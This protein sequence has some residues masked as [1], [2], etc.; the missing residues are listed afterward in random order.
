MLAGLSAL[1]SILLQTKNKEPPGI[2]R[3]WFFEVD[4]SDLRHQ[5][6]LLITASS[7]F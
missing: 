5:L 4:F 2:G 3:F 1:R 7:F 6:K